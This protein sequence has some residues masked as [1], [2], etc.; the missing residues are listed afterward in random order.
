LYVKNFI[1]FV[2]TFFIFFR[3]NITVSVS[4]VSI[5]VQGLRYEVQLLVFINQWS[6]NPGF[7]TQGG[8]YVVG[9][10]LLHNEDICFFGKSDRCVWDDRNGKD[11]AFVKAHFGIN[12]LFVYVWEE[13]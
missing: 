3:L 9:R 2:L 8:Y 6:I 4:I 11:I 1:K 13:Y 10:K 5:E 7:T 12:L